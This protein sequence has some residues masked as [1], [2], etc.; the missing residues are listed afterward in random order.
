MIDAELKNK[1]RNH[2]S[3]NI[4]KI[5][6]RLNISFLDRGNGC[7][8][9]ACPC[10]QHGGD[11]NNRTAFSWKSDI[12]RW[13]CWTHHCEEN[14]G[15]DIF[16]LVRSILGIGFSDTIKWIEDNLSE[17]NIDISSPVKP[18]IINKPQTIHIHDPLSENNIKFL[19]PDPI[20]LINRGFSKEILRDYQI[21]LWQR[22][23]T[24]MNDRVIVPI[25]DHDG[26]LIG[27]S[28][29]TIH[30]ESYFIEKNIEYRKWIH[31]RSF[32][33]WPKIGELFTGS[34]LFNLNRAKSRIKPKNR[35]ILVEGPLDGIKLEMAGIHNWIATLGTKF[36]SNHRT[37]LVKY[38]ITDLFVAYDNDPP[39]GP[40]Q[41]KPGE[42]GWER[43]LKIVGQL[44]HCHRVQLPENS[45]CGDL[46]IF[47]LQDIFK[48][49][50]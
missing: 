1:L 37:L 42:E 50:K 4:E 24:F 11:R 8:Q 12:G 39:K 20:Y 49:I 30:N 41:S 15:S 22:K 23:G 10:K 13:I 35:I 14:F 44:F 34:I 40:K 7:F 46:P 25:R 21:G 18:I 27:Y 31:G 38:G 26:F 32:N 17:N 33:Q 5:F 2:A 45:D 9:A 48:D 47:Q 6:D 36:S 43:L 29:R 3:H 19:K 16:G 28:G